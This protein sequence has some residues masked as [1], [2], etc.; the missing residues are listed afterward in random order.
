MTTPAK[1]IFD[2]QKREEYARLKMNE[3]LLELYEI[4]CTAVIKQKD[5]QEFVTNL[6]IYSDSITRE[7]IV[8]A[9]KVLSIFYIMNLKQEI[10]IM[11][12]MNNEDLASEIRD[13]YANKKMSILTNSEERAYQIE[14]YKTFITKVSGLSDTFKT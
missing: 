11:D 7:N 6:E 12:I 14:I 13:R 3:K 8:E 4:F 5:H 9:T 2:M 10:E 1:L